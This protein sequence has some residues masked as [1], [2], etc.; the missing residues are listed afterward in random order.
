M[1]C[2]QFLDL[3][4]KCTDRFVDFT[5]TQTQIENVGLVSATDHPHAKFSAILCD[6]IT[7]SLL[8]LQL[9]RMLK[10]VCDHLVSTKEAYGFF[11]T[12]IDLGHF[13]HFINQAGLICCRTF[14]FLNFR[15][16]SRREL[17]VRHVCQNEHIFADLLLSQE[18][19]ANFGCFVR[20][21]HEVSQAAT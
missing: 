21:H 20:S 11:D 14:K 12:R 7:N 18:F 4:N 19:V 16:N 2:L 3:F 5:S 8:S 1:V 9:T 6:Q 17:P 10:R 13:N 15:M